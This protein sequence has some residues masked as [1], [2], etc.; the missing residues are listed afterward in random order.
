MSDSVTPAE[1]PMHP[2]APR[3][4]NRGKKP[5]IGPHIDDYHKAHKETIGHESDA[6]WAKVSS[7]CSAYADDADNID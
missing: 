7:T 3:M 2:V 1:I 6:W 5:H 4:T